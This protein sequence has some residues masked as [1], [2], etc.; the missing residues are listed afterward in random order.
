MNPQQ[1]FGLQVLLSL[2]VYG[3]MARWYVT[4]TLASQPLPA[5]LQPLLVLHAFRHL[6]TVFLRHPR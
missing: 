4:P 3:L 1:I 5:A 2:L 6:G